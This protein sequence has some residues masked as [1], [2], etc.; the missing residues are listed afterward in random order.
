[1]LNAGAGNRREN[2]IQDSLLMAL[3]A[4]MKDLDVYTI[5]EARQTDFL[6]L[7][8]SC[9]YLKKRG[10]P[11]CILQAGRGVVTL[12]GMAIIGFKKWAHGSGI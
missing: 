6:C 3:E 2:S 12:A 4:L 11:R 8:V 10:K 9:I 7:G 5:L 1:M